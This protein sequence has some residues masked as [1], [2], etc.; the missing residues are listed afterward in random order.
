MEITAG[1]VVAFL[2]TP[3]HGEPIEFVY[4]ATK[5]LNSS[6][7]TEVWLVGDAD[8]QSYVL[9]VY[10]TEADAADPDS[11]VAPIVFDRE[12]SCLMT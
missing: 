4:H 3:A 7:H 12:G 9:K 1:N 2:E 5:R 11:N 8:G 10:G 6:T